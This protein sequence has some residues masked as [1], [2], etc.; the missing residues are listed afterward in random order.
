MITLT[1]N[2]KTLTFND[3]PN[4][5][6]LWF[7]REE[8]GMTGTKFGCGVAMCGACTVHLDGKPVRSCQTTMAQAAG[9]N[10]TTIESIHETAIGKV[11]QDAWYDLDVVQCGFCQSGQIMSATALLTEKKQPTD[12]DIDAAMSGNVC[13]CATYTRIRQA[14]HVAAKKLDEA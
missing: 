1:L 14:I 5:P 2:N 8:V 3:D 6:L 11:V 13:R 4:M 7:L 12:A 9:K 10:I